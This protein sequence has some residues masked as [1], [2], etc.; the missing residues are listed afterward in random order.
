M[1]KQVTGVGCVGQVPE[2]GSF[3][4]AGLLGGSRSDSV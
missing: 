1:D 2:A 3:G 4:D